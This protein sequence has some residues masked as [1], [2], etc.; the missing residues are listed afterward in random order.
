MPTSTRDRS[1]ATRF[2]VALL[3][4]ALA[5]TGGA[6]RADASSEV[7]ELSPRGDW[8][9]ALRRIDQAVAAEPRNVSLRFQRGVVLMDSG[10]DEQA[11]ALFT[12]L[13]QEHPDLPDPYNNLALL[14]ARAGR[15]E[16]ALAAVQ[17]ALRAEPAHRVARTN[18][19]QLHL[20]L[21]VRTW[22]GLAQSGPVDASLLKR[23]EAARALLAGAAPAG[24]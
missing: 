7:R 2:A 13:A 9:G 3:P 20:M 22:D 4:L 19:G 14:H 17:E 21:A 10:K 16:Q 24:R 8:S 15:L 5:F 12:Q 6:S 18:L 11:L 23:L 1:L